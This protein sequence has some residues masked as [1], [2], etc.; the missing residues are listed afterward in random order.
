MPTVTKKACQ[1]CNK[2]FP[3]QTI[4]VTEIENYWLMTCPNCYGL[5]FSCHSCEYA[6]KCNF[7][8]D[9]SEPQMVQ[10]TIRQGAAIIS[11]AVKNPHL[12]EKHCISCRCSWGNKGNCSRENDNGMHCSNYHMMPELFKIAIPIKGDKND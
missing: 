12:I 6:N 3:L 8:N 4:V 7:A 9:H 1:I 10:Q 5:L 2:E 11:T